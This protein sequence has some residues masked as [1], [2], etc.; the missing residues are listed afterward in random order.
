MPAGIGS[1][2]TSSGHN[3]PT[4]TNHPNPNSY[5]HIKLLTQELITIDTVKEKLHIGSKY[6]IKGKGMPMNDKQIEYGDLI[7]S[8]SAPA[9]TTSG[10]QSHTWL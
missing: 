5:I 8:I 1:S 2:S 10:H 3:H 9:T 7:V 6:V 4:A